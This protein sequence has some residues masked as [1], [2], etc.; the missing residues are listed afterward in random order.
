MGCNYYLRKRDGSMWNIPRDRLGT[1]LEF[2]CKKEFDKDSSVSLSL[3]LKECIEQINELH[4]G[5]SSF[6]WH[7]SL[8]IYPILNI[9]TLKDWEKLF[10][11]QDDY[12]IIDEEDRVINPGD[13][14]DT[15]DSYLSII[16]HDFPNIFNIIHFSNC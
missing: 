10:N 15:I 3:D 12:V 8:C 4:I 5:K 2:L 11:N 1:S 6:G 9:Y 7:F 14:L 13:M 16:I